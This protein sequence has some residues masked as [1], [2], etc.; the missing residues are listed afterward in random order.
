MERP[1]KPEEPPKPASGPRAA[2]EAERAARDADPQVIS[3]AEKAK[4]AAE[5][6]RNEYAWRAGAS[7]RQA[8]STSGVF[9]LGRRA[10][11]PWKE[12][13][14]RKRGPFGFRSGQPPD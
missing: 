10:C 13:P 9:G 3:G 7:R 5:A 1:P 2:S 12:G 14:R 11:S 6:A 4:L 8:R